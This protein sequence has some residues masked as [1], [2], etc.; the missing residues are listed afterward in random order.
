MNYTFYKLCSFFLF[1]LNFGL[2]GLCFSH[3]KF[4][5][6]SRCTIFSLSV[7]LKVKVNYVFFYS[8]YLEV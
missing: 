7:Y 4:T 8:I 1:T 6:R 2:Y 5:L 3:T